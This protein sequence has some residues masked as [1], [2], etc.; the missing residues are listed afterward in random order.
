[1]PIRELCRSHRQS[2]HGAAIHAHTVRRSDCRL[3]LGFARLMSTLL[4][5]M[6]LS[7]SLSSTP[8][9]DQ[10]I[11]TVEREGRLYVAASA[12]IRESGIAIK[13]LPGQGQLAA[14]CQERCALVKDFLKEGNETLVEVESLA[15]ALGASAELDG[16][17]R[18][19]SFRLQDK[20]LAENS[21]SAGVG[22]LAP[23]FRLRKLDGSPVALADFR[24]KRVLINSWAS[25]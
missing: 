9:T 25:W 13:S 15:K 18:Q 24:G 1:M 22:Q 14:C 19:V 17:R 6:G 10:M 11:P 16:S 20:S 8:A 3:K 7:A 23:N 5:G 2:A 21:S 4:L 12:L